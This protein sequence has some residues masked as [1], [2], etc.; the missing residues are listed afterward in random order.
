MR[1]DGLIINCYLFKMKARFFITF[2]ATLMF[3]SLGHAEHQEHPETFYFKE[4]D[5]FRFG[6]KTTM[7]ILM[8][9]LNAAL[10]QPEP[11]TEVA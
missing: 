8:N 9:I 6:S 3:A 5:K 7:S 10:K 2:L 4:S 11:K 1:L